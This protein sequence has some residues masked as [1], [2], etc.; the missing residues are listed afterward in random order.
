M[1][2]FLNGKM[3]YWGRNKRP[4]CTVG[5]GNIFIKEVINVVQTEIFADAAVS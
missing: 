5:N 2:F 1:W 3:R 4:N